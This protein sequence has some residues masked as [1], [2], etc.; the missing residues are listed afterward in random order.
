[1]G[2]E[3]LVI[4]KY[5]LF[6][7]EDFQGYH[8]KS[9]RDFTDLILN[10]YHWR[11][12]NQELEND[13]ET[14]QLTTYIWIINKN[15]QVFLYRRALGEGYK[16]NRHI[17]RYSGG[18]G[19]HIDKNENED[20]QNPIDEAIMRELTE[21]VIMK[22][23]PFP[24]ITGFVRD[25]SDVYNSVHLG[26]VGIVQVDWDVKA[27]DGMSSGQ[28]YTIEEVDNILNDQK[29]DADQWTRICWPFI[30]EYLESI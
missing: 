29:N 2:K 23:Y 13:L 8:E 19:G 20:Q 26:V 24:N 30:K 11:E 25:T 15:K 6:K 12:R 17:G 21:E 5:I 7:E 3:I 22:E 10:N 1:M 27:A 9:K 4:N 28:F 16:E 18:V 14:I